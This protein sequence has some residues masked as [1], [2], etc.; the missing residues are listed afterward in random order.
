VF[1]LISVVCP[2]SSL[3]VHLIG[4]KGKDRPSLIESDYCSDLLHCEIHIRF[5]IFRRRLDF[6]VSLQKIIESIR[7]QSFRDR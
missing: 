6:A 7:Q 1:C 3:L 5:P 2:F 4:W